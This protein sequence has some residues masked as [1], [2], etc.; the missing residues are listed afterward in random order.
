M[1][2][3]LI[4][5]TSI[6][7]TAVLVN[8]YVAIARSRGVKSNHGALKESSSSYLFLVCALSGSSCTSKKA[9]YAVLV[10]S[11]RLLYK[12]HRKIDGIFEFDDD[13]AV[14]HVFMPDKIGF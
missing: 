6:N 8:L 5:F 10:P 9:R 12:V 4:I 2:I 1:I 3:L 11:S 14:E 7:R 13:V